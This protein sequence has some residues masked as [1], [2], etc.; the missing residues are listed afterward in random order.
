MNLLLSHFH[1]D[2]HGVEPR[3]RRHNQML[4]MMMMGIIIFLMVFVPMGFNFLGV[5]GGK[6]FLMAKLALLLASVNGLR[7]V[8]K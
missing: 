5:I 7:R 1:V 6:S 4:P 2:S 3:R 8:S